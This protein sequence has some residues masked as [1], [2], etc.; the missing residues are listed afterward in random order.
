MIRYPL[1][2]VVIHLK[3]RGQ[4]G[5]EE[6]WRMGG[7]RQPR[8]GLPRERKVQKRGGERGRSDHGGVGYVLEEWERRGEGR[9]KDGIGRGVAF[10]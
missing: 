8:P 5:D 7:K 3:R 1:G 2:T 4:G 9:E 10:F 6:V